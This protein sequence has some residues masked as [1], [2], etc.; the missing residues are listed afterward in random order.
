VLLEA[1]PQPQQLHPIAAQLARQPR[2]GG[3]LGDATEDQQDLGGPSLPAVEDRA[4]EG[5]EDPAAV[6]TLVIEDRGA[7]AAMDAEAV[8][9]PA[10][11]AGQAGGVEPVQELGVAGVL[12][13]ELDQGEVHRCGPHIPEHQHRDDITTRSDRQGSSTAPAS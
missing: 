3:P 13:Q 11:G 7:M 4:G 12:V 9:G 2:G 5:V 6:A 8:A 1:V 10:A